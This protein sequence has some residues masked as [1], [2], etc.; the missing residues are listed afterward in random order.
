MQKTEIKSIGGLML[1]VAISLCT[2]GFLLC[3]TIIGA[4]IGLPMLIL[5]AI[6][7]LLSLPVMIVEAFM[8]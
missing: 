4:V 6:L 2:V 1:I 8:R 5:G 3:L 7:G